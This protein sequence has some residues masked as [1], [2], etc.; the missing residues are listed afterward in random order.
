MRSAAGLVAVAVGEVAVGVVVG[1]ILNE[2]S[3]DEE[4]DDDEEDGEE[5][6]PDDDCGLHSA[7]FGSGWVRAMD[8]IRAMACS[9]EM[10]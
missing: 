9:W 3:D 1:S 6:D 10:A 8:G 7:P 4:S 2:E 5:T